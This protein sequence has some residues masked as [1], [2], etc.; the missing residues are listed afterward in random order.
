MPGF[1]LT[2]GLTIFYLS[3]VV[4]LPLS[5]LAAKACEISPGQLWS[6]IVSPRALAAYKLSFGGA[7]LA[8]AI[9]VVAGLLLAWVLVR[10]RFFGRAL[11]DADGHRMRSRTTGVF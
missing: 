2:L 11:V 6:T 4:I 3:I 7:F 8:A 5:A 9:N 1:H 10:Y